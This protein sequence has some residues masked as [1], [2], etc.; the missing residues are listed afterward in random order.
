MI[1][2]SL[3]S[4]VLFRL[5]S[6]DFPGAHYGIG[7]AASV[8]NFVLSIIVGAATY[9]MI[10]DNGFIKSISLNM[11]SQEEDQEIK[12]ITKFNTL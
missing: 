12:V 1:S 3:G 9:Y 2:F 7:F 8:I 11:F 10:D 5:A 4:G 6:R